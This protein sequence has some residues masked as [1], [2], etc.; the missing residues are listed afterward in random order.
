MWRFDKWGTIVVA[1]VRVTMMTK[2]ALRQIEEE[3]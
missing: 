2:V 3:E 1:L